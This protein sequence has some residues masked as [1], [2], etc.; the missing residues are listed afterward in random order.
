MVKVTEIF[1]IILKIFYEFYRQ[2][3]HGEIGRKEVYN[4]VKN[5]INEND[6]DATIYYMK[7]K[8]MIK[9]S[10]FWEGWF[11]KITAYGIE[12]IEIE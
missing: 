4:K 5:E 2:S 8:G 1:S 11:G 3:P 6:F 10:E 7:G 9:I 12:I